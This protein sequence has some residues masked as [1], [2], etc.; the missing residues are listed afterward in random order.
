[1]EQHLIDAN[2]LKIS[3]FMDDVSL[4]TN[5]SDPR[6]LYYHESWDWLIPVIDKITSMDEYF[7]YKQ[8]KSGQFEVNIEINTKFIMRTYEDVIDFLNWMNKTN[9]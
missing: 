9:E 3:K 5:M 7:K 2:N 4:F 1:M 6:N 8:E